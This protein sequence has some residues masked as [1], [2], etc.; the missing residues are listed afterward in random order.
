[1]INHI[2]W[3]SVEKDGWPTKKGVYL[4]VRLTNNPEGRVRT[5]YLYSI[6]PPEWSRCSL[7]EITHYIPIE[8]IPMPKANNG[9]REYYS[10]PYRAILDES[11][12]IIFTNLPYSN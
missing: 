10:R 3:H 5:D 1:M 11:G 4:I 12:N 6:D 7:E 9:C 2:N 8:D